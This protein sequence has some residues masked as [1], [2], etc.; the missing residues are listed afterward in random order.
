MTNNKARLLVVDDEPVVRMSYTRSLAADFDAQTAPDGD[1]ALREMEREPADVVLL[2]LRL[3]GAH[4]LEV[5]QTM[6]R[7]WPETEVV[8]ITGYPSVDSAK[9]AVRLGAADYLAKPVGPDEL[10]SAA[11]SAL[12]RKQWT[13][14]IH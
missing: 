11:R 2:D 14:H 9:Q 3:P 4:G 13:L 12:L 10:M 5:L 1:E 8:V 6:K 7:K